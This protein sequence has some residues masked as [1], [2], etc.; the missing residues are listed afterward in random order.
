MIYPPKSNP[1][2]PAYL[3]RVSVFS[4]SYPRLKREEKKAEKGV[5]FNIFSRFFVVY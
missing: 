3:Y 2:L 5:F 4:G 1:E